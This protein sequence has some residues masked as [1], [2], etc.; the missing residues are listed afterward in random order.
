MKCRLCDV[1]LAF[2]IKLS[3]A[4][5][6]SITFGADTNK[7]CHFFLRTF[8]IALLAELLICFRS[9]TI[10]RRSLFVFSAHV[11]LLRLFCQLAAVL[12]R[13]GIGFIND[14][15]YRGN[16][17]FLRELAPKALTSLRIPKSQ[18]NITDVCVLSDSCC[19]QHFLLIAT[20]EFINEFRVSYY[21]SRVLQFIQK[22]MLLKKTFSFV[23]L[24]RSTGPR[25]ECSALQMV[26]VCL[27]FVSIRLK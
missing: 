1:E 19:R 27:F 18:F 23:L 20:E 12:A 3:C 5:E 2:L 14:L 25:A 26:L 15:H 4:L 11:I 16:F 10:K 22:F 17:L 9:N 24:L 13:F 7:F 21:F 8:E 6:V